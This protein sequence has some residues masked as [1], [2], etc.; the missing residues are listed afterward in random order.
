MV[1]LVL[2]IIKSNPE[3]EILL[4]FLILKKNQ[5]KIS[6]VDLNYLIK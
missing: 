6:T 1:V 3:S 4:Q 2:N 5:S